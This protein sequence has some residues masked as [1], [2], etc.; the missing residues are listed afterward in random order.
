MIHI[1]SID[2]KSQIPDRSGA[3]AGGSTRSTHSFGEAGTSA[4]CL[5]IGTVYMA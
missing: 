1:R 3:C 5:C 2:L 4:S